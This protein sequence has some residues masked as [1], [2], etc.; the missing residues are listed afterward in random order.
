MQREY[1]NSQYE[2]DLNPM[3]RGEIESN[4]FGPTDE[5]YVYR[6]RGSS[7]DAMDAAARNLRYLEEAVAS[8]REK[9]HGKVRSD[10]EIREET[11]GVKLHLIQEQLLHDAEY[12]AGAAAGGRARTLTGTGEGQQAGHVHDLL[13]SQ[14]WA[15]DKKE[16]KK[17]RASH[18]AQESVKGLSNQG[19]VKDKKD[20]QKKKRLTGMGGAGSAL[21]L[22]ARM[23]ALPVATKEEAVLATPSGH[24]R[25]HSQHSQMSSRALGGGSSRVLGG[26]GAAGKPGAVPEAV[27]DTVP[28]EASAGNLAHLI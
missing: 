26:G 5:Q 23:A 8:G 20:V 19:W 18:A 7:L 13:G 12:D 17:K 24:S 15:K 1:G 11:G 22:A 27:P 16:I 3:R 21:S 4:D 9:Q 25:A 6:R 28:E 14:G 2:L 10:S